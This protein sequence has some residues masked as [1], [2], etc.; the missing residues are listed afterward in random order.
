M[1]ALFKKRYALVLSL[2]F[3]ILL[4]SNV[5]MAEQIELTFMFRGGQLQE[6]LVNYWIADFEAKNPDIKIVWRTATGD[7]MDQMPIWIASGQAP[8]VFEMWGRQARDWGEQGFLMDLAPY[9]ARDF[10]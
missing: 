3:G 4:F 5:A 2:L 6:E 7:W 1:N 8:D 10:T 9:V